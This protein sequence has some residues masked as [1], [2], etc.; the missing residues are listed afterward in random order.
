MKI[1][2]DSEEEKNEIIEQFS[3]SDYCP[4]HFYYVYGMSDDSSK[5]CK[6][7]R[8]KDCWRKAIEKLEVKD[9]R[10]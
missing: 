7:F 1:I 4:S 2:F 3:W 9:D 5:D 8:C 10:E 6:H